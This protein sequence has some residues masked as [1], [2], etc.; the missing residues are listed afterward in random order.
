MRIPSNLR[1]AALAESKRGGSWQRFIGR[2]GEELRRAEPYN[3]AAYRR[4]RSELYLLVTSNPR[5]TND[6]SPTPWE[7]DDTRDKQLVLF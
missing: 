2:H 1:T 4:L 6:D 3:L 5:R 7:R